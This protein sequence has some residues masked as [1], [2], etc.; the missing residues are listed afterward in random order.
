MARQLKVDNRITIFSDIQGLKSITSYSFFPRSCSIQIKVV[1]C[2]KKLG[3]PGNK[4][5]KEKGNQA[6]KGIPMRMAQNKCFTAV[7]RRN[8]FGPGQEDGSLLDGCLQD[9][10]SGTDLLPD[11]VDLL[12]MISQFCQIN[13]S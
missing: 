11:V 12:R 10:T 2:I 3:H 4:G 6:V 8:H 7:L 9:K 1:P 5:P 13:Y